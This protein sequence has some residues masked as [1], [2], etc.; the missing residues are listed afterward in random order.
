MKKVSIIL[1][2]IILI[3][4][5]YYLSNR[6]NN[7]NGKN[8]PVA[9]YEHE[10]EREEDNPDKTHEEVRGEALGRFLRDKKS[11]NS[12]KSK[13]S[14]GMLSLFKHSHS[15]HHG[16]SFYHQEKSGVASPARL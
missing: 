16:N 8:L 11:P 9:H 15:L 6:N 3:A 7:L 4:S 13:Q 5:F 1:I 12:D 2:A 10:K 14:L